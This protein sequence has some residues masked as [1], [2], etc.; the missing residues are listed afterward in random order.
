MSD[1]KRWGNGTISDAGIGV[2]PRKTREL[3]VL[4]KVLEVGAC[5]RIWRGT[6]SEKSCSACNGM[7]QHATFGRLQSG[8]LKLSRPISTRCHPH[9][10]R[11]RKEPAKVEGASGVDDPTSGVNEV[12]WIEVKHTFQLHD[13]FGHSSAQPPQ[14]LGSR[15]MRCDRG[16]L[17]EEES[18]LGLAERLLDVL[19][20]TECYLLALRGRRH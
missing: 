19:R 12:K 13:K 16:A 2:D 18:M 14:F 3:S 9:L 17:G 4:R 20:H 5:G 8:P 15:W 6:V 11:T 10:P 1:G 7:V